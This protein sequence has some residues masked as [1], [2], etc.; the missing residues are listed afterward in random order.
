[1]QITNREW[2]KIM[3]HLNFTGHVYM[4]VF[5]ALKS[6]FEVFCHTGY[7]IINHI[8]DCGEQKNVFL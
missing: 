7:L 8:Y 3:Y 5:K 4:N 1:M 2:V 6:E